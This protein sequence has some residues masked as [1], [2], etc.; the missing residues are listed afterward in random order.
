MGSQVRHSLPGRDYRW[1]SPP[2]GEVFQPDRDRSSARPVFRGR[3][4]RRHPSMDLAGIGAGGP[5]VSLPFPRSPVLTQIRPAAFEF[6]PTRVI[7]GPNAAAPYPPHRQSVA[8][9][10]LGKKTFERLGPGCGAFPG[11]EIRRSDVIRPR[12]RARPEGLR[13]R[14]ERILCLGGDGTPFEVINGLYSAAGRR[15]VEMGS[16]RPARATRSSGISA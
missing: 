7:S 15:A 10:G 14:H 16:F 3:A 13:R 1:A 6:A 2:G 4:G 5:L 8:G 9:H 11:L 12:H